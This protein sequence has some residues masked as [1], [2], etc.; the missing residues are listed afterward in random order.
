MA[1]ACASAAAAVAGQSTGPAAV[2]SPVQRRGEAVDK[3]TVADARLTD[4][5]VRRRPLAQATQDTA[6][7][8]GLRCGD[9]GRE[10]LEQQPQ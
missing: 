9:G 8:I 2:R 3:C 6:V 1:W 10:P 7:H 4:T 5:L